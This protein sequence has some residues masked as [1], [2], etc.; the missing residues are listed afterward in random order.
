MARAN[1]SK[2]VL[3]EALELINTGHADKAVAV[4][5]TAIEENPK[6]VN[7]LG[8][9]GAIYTKMGRYRDASV[10]LKATI[11]M[12]PSFAKPHEDL[13]FVLLELRQPTEALDVLKNATRLDPSLE[14]AHFLMGKA[15]GMLAKGK[16]ADEAYEKSFDLNPE[17]KK[18]A[19]AAEH[20][21]E[22]RHEQA[23][24]LY[25]EILQKNPKNVDALRLLGVVAFRASR[26]D[27]AERLIK[28]SID[29]APD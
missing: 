20:H 19:L 7:M 1:T 16:E 10:A 6:N 25:K 18:L 24:K 29:L 13:G 23:E 14:R 12:A 17:R 3:N 11:E 27:D 15:L 4:C 22:G 5:L 8:M 9:L 2:T 21:K 26:L 28:K